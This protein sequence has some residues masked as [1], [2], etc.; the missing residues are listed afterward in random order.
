MRRIVVAAG[1][2][3]LTALV[4]TAPIVAQ[5]HGGVQPLCSGCGYGA[6]PVSVTGPTGPDTVPGDGALDS[7]AFTVKNTGSTNTDT[8]FLTASCVTI[9]CQLA[10]F[11]NPNPSSLY[12]GHGTWATAWVKFYHPTTASS[13]SVSLTAADTFDFRGNGTATIVARG[14]PPP[15]VSLAP[16]NSTGRDF[17]RCAASCFF[18]TYVQGTVPYF[19][20]DTP[21]NVTLVYRSAFSD[22]RPIVLLDVTHGG[23]G[24]NLPQY[25]Y[26][27][28][29][30][31]V[32][33]SWLGVSF[34]N[35]ESELRF[36][37]AAGAAYRLGGQFAA[38]SNGMS[39]DSV[40]QIR[41]LVGA[42]YGAS[43]R[44]EDTV[45]SRVIIL[46]NAAAPF[47]LGWG[48]AG[49]QR[50]IAVGDSALVEEGDGSAWYYTR[51]GT[52]SYSTPS[53]AFSVLSV[54]GSGPST[55]WTRTYPDSSRVVFDNTGHMI[56]AINR[57]SDTVAYAWSG[58]HL[59][60]ITDPQHLS[61]TVSRYDSTGNHALW[62]QDPGGRLTQVWV[63][64]T[65]GLL[66]SITDPDGHS[67]SF[68]YDGANRLR[69]VTNRNSQTVHSMAYDAH[70]K[71][72]VADSGPSVPVY[73]GGSAR[74]I[75]T[76]SPWPQVSVPYSSTQSAPYFT[77]ARSDTVRGY[78][79]DPGGHR[80]SIAVN[81]MGQPVVTIDPVG[82]STSTLY[83]SAF[84]V[85][86]VMSNMEP[87]VGVAYSSDGLPT[88]LTTEGL[89][90][91][92]HYAAWAQP[93]SVWGDGVAFSR[94]RIGLHGRVD[95]VD[96]AR[97]GPTAL[98]Y[99]SHGRVTQEWYADGT[100]LLKRWYNGANGNF[101]RDSSMSSAP[102]E[103]DH[104][105]TYDAL[106]RLVTTS[107]GQGVGPG[108]RDSVVYDSMNRVT[109]HFDSLGATPSRFGYDG[110]FLRAVTDAMGNVD[111]TW[112]NA[113]G[114]AIRHRDA[115]GNVDSVQYDV[116]GLVRQT[117]N[118]RGQT[119]VMSYDAAHRPTVRSGSGVLDSLSYVGDSVVV[120]WNAW[121]RDSIFVDRLGRA[122]S[123]TTTDSGSAGSVTS[124]QY[125]VY[126][127]TGLL[128]SSYS[129][130]PVSFLSRKFGYDSAAVLDSIRLAATGWTILQTNNPWGQSKVRFPGGDSLFSYFDGSVLH[131]VTYAHSSAI[132][133]DDDTY[134][135]DVLSR[136]SQRFTV[137][138]Y[139]FYG[140]DQLR[141]LQSEQ[142]GQD[143]TYGCE[144]SWD[145]GTSYF[146]PPWSNPDSTH[147]FTYDANDNR[148]DH[149][150][151]YGP[152]NRIRSFNG[153]SDSTDADG[154]VTW[155]G[156]THLFWS[157]DGLLD[158]VRRAGASTIAYRYDPSG[159]L[160]R[161]DSA[162]VATSLFVWRGQ[163]LLAELGGS[164][165]PLRAEYS[166]YPDLD[167]LHAMYIPSDT[168]VGPAYATTDPLGNVSDLATSTTTGRVVE[169]RRFAYDAWGNLVGGSDIA[170]Y[171][172]FDR[173]RWKGAL[174]FQNDAGLYYMRSRWYDPATGRF[175][176]EDPD[177]I[178]PGDNPYVFAYDDPVNLSD[179]EGAQVPL[180]PINTGGTNN[181]CPDGTFWVDQAINYEHCIP[182]T[183]YP[184]SITRYGS[185]IVPQGWEFDGCDGQAGNR[186]SECVARPT[187]PITLAEALKASCLA[188][189]ASFVANVAGDVV[190]VAFSY[191]GGA[192]VGA[193]LLDLASGSL[194]ETVGSAP[195]VLPRL[196]KVAQSAGTFAQVRGYFLVGAGATDVTN[197]LT[198]PD[199][200][201]SASQFTGD[202]LTS[203][204][205]SIDAWRSLHDCM[206]HGE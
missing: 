17:G 71:L 65:D 7:I 162:G 206:H 74:P 96:I 123:I 163:T 205:G 35:G 63:S 129:T 202:G 149:G 131:D 139:R 70:S 194:L 24:T 154:N 195:E 81:A 6:S 176:S 137:D 62:I 116:E 150:A 157:V 5:S 148:V 54:T 178:T 172:G 155:I 69:T 44:V 18:T 60:S 95:S 152:G 104:Y 144:D 130:G 120:E 11:H 28:L 122:R 197:H 141:R 10:K 19:S 49:V 26:L 8:Y 188:E 158:S 167:R 186:M 117:R 175:L 93:D 203:V 47:G 27:K 135:T 107:V 187:V 113:A 89:G 68:G 119:V 180:N 86:S 64:Y 171:A 190:L 199:E 30:R 75:T 145:E 146:C 82:D 66:Q 41:A 177:Q 1:L 132:P 91:Y 98:A 29:Q 138:G 85:D 90:Q 136:L 61:I 78:I 142:F 36:A 56:Y 112:Y 73:G 48:A 59:T 161:R 52:S 55:R 16:Y 25:F 124:H 83:T 169:R 101:S 23:D 103:I 4:F 79:T 100:L 198:S 147:S 53:G 72:V 46:H 109:Q 164:G 179:P 39:R 37:A 22:P 191:K 94:Y 196:G 134:S 106:G 58:A 189:A 84:L 20:L 88:R 193:G 201:I 57:W 51:S 97:R 156:T 34:V 102:G 121:A 12:L 128:D 200:P 173:A 184:P 183:Q 67:T 165:S 2:V 166:Y 32:S 170:H 43:G 77:P 159:R 133:Y 14:G 114:W 160:V 50:L 174:S 192:L 15:V 76:F 110:I 45:S 38:D 99:D 87:R 168:A 3:A 108:F 125:F 115:A 140:Y 21:R 204:F 31:Y 126:R 9:T 127:S 80:T 153:I 105:Y 118:R 92:W 181:K 143:S 151:T 33:G 40:Y 182:F 111:S 13:G 185:A 42:D